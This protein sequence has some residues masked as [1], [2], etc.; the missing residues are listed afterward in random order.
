MTWCLP[1]LIDDVS[2]FPNPQNALLWTRAVG[3]VPHKRIPYC[4]T[5]YLLLTTSILHF[6]S[7]Q[8]RIVHRCCSSLK[9]KALNSIGLPFQLQTL[10]QTAAATSE[11]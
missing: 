5:Y 1:F 7:R 2:G 9:Q 8:C 4:C 3:H 6:I 11:N 10:V